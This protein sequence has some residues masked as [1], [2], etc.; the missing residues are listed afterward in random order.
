LAGIG[1]GVSTIMCFEEA[2]DGALGMARSLR[3]LQQGGWP[4]SN[5]CRKVRQTANLAR[6]RPVFYP[7]ITASCDAEEIHYSTNPHRTVAA[8]LISATAPRTLTHVPLREV[9]Y[10]T[11][12][13]KASARI[14]PWLGLYFLLPEFRPYRRSVFETADAEH[15]LANWSASS[16]L[17]RPSSSGY[18]RG[19]EAPAIEAPPCRGRKRKRWRAFHR[20]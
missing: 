17:G 3:D 9:G 2:H 1:S 20:G 15:V 12:P 13:P 4:S 16:S 10:R 19:H 6:Y 7:A 18:V 14:I 8:I 11:A 5:C